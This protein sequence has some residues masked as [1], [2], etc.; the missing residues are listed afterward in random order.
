MLPLSFKEYISYKGETDLQQ[1]YID[2][3][4]KSS[5]PY[6]MNLENQKEIRTYLDGIYNTIIIKDIVTRI[7]I[8]DVSQLDS[9]VK[10]MFDNVGNLF[11]STKIANVMTS[12]GRSISVPTVEN[13]LKLL[14]DSFVLYKVN[15]YDIKRKQ[16]LASGAKYYLSDIGLRYYLLGSKKADEGHILENVVY[17][18]L[19][20]RGYEV[21]VG[22]IENNEVDFIAINENGE[23]YYQVA[24]T[25]R[26][27]ETLKKE[28]SNLNNIKDHNPKYL[29]T[30]DFTPYTSHNGIKQ[31]NVL[32]WLLEK[33]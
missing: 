8:S 10:F 17:L 2:Y 24:Y 28:L 5:F 21:Y 23:E 31:I 32:D 29:L 30:M 27:E 9:I 16:Y 18:E 11:S 25:V 19:L 12:N 33:N 13:Y 15:R 14:I 4:T 3:I 26:E 22:K 20:R 7:K 6:T 1:K